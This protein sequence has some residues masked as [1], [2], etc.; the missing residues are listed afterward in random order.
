M[1]TDRIKQPIIKPL[2]PTVTTVKADPHYV[3][4]RTYIVLADPSRGM[5]DPSM[6]RGRSIAR[7]SW[8]R[9]LN[10]LDLNQGLPYRQCAHPQLHSRRK[11][12]GPHGA[13][14]QRGLRYVA[15]GRGDAQYAMLTG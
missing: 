11:P 13:A 10:T 1:R 9:W 5:I 4:N 2:V 3:P 7:V 14:L 6:S 12:P 8:A 15:L